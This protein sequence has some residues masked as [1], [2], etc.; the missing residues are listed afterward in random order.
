MHTEIVT[1]VAGSS[2]AVRITWLSPNNILSNKRDV[3]LTKICYHFIFISKHTLDTK[4]S[5]TQNAYIAG[6]NKSTAV[7]VECWQASPS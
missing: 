1:R 4:S 5:N 6:A 7:Q 2:E 3:T